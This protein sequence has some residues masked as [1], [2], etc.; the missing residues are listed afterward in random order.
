MALTYLSSFDQYPPEG[1]VDSTASFALAGV[2]GD[3]WTAPLITDSHARYLAQAQAEIGR[4]P[5][6]AR[7]GRHAFIMRAASAIGGGGSTYDIDWT[8]GLLRSLPD[9]I[10]KRLYHIAFSCSELP[11]VARAHGNIMSFIN[12][13]DLVR[14]R[15]GVGPAGQLMVMP[16]ALSVPGLSDTGVTIGGL[17]AQSA[18][19]VIEPRTWY[20]LSIYMDT[21]GG[22][23]AVDIYV[24]PIGA[25][26]KVLSVSGILDW[27]SAISP[28][29]PDPEITQVNLLPFSAACTKFGSGGVI[30]ADLTT[31]AVRDFVIHDDLGGVN[32]G[33]LGQITASWHPFRGARVDT[34]FTPT[35]GGSAIEDVL[36]DPDAA[37]YETAVG[38]TAQADLIARPLARDV[39]H[40]VG[41]QV[42]AR[43]SRSDSGAVVG[44][45]G[46]ADREDTETSGALAFTVNDLDTRVMVDAAMTAGAFSAGVAR[47]ERT[48]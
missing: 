35:P 7:Q 6:G 20:S 16:D 8:G 26:T 40:L 18:A 2:L 3:G 41:A 19:G 42:T 24:G 38:P 39:S 28:N 32:D 17:N 31:R 5:W 22:E 45:L 12:D 23:V 21:S 34:G 14:G 33:P 25:A 10:H 27:P 13:Y 29:P 36:N 9:K 48:A 15:I 11:K 37:T 1:P 4:P 47:I 44:T 30:D 46:F 43:G